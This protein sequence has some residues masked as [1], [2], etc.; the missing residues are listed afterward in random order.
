VATVWFEGIEELYEI[1]ADLGKASAKTKA[2]AAVVLNKSLAD[3][4]RDAKAIVPV[5]T[6]NLK[7]SISRTKATAQNLSGEVGPTAS[8][9]GY[10]NWGTEFM[11]PQPYMDP[12]FD[13]HWPV[14][15][16][17]I[18]SIATPI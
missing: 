11:G 13:K 8:Y 3:I 6:G 16:A 12:P 4:E 2:K 17:A 9:G 1:A 18:A 7:A 14:F 15:T 10:V 5:D